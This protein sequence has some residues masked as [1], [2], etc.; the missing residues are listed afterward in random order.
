MAL[1]AIGGTVPGPEGVFEGR[2]QEMHLNA[3]SLFFGLE[4]EIESRLFFFFPG[5]TQSAAAAPFSFPFHLPATSRT[6]Y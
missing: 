1:H 5:A 3:I 2:E 6:P 4:E